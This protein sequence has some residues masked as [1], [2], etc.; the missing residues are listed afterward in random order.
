MAVKPD[1]SAA[2]DVMKNL[3]AKKTEGTSANPAAKPSGKPAPDHKVKVNPKAAGKSGGAAH[4]R[5]S[6]RGK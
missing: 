6:N 4:M 3:T 1:L 5:S 2:A